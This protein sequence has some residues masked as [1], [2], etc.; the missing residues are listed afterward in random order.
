MAKKTRHEKEVAELRRQLEVLKAQTKSYQPEP[1]VP[2]AIEELPNNRKTETPVKIRRVDPK[3]IK[4]DL[5]KTLVLTILAL[6]LIGLAV[7]IL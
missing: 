5:L 1:I 2:V 3:F 7:L 6:A 4:K